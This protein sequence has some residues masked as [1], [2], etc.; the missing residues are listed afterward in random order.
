MTGRGGT[1]ESCPRK[2]VAMRQHAFV[3]DVPP[4]DAPPPVPSGMKRK[5]RARGFRAYAPSAGATT[6]L[7]PRVTLFATSVAVV[8]LLFAMARYMG[9]FDT[10]TDKV[11]E[12]EA[13]PKIGT[14]PADVAAA[15]KI[16]AEKRAFAEGLFGPE[17]WQEKDATEFDESPEWAK[18][19]ATMAKLDPK[20]VVDHLDF[21]LN[22]D[23]DEAIKDPAAFR[24]RM[25]R[26]R[27]LV[28]SNFRAYRLK[29]PVEGREDVFR[30]LIA[31]TDGEHPVFFDVLDAPP[32]FRTMVEKPPGTDIVFSNAD[33]VDVDGVFLRT[34]R[35]ETRGDPRDPKNNP[36][37]WIDVPWVIA[38]TVVKCQVEEEPSNV[39][40]YVGGTA[41][42]LALI[43]L[44]VYLVR[45]DSRPR[46]VREAPPTGFRTMFAQRLDEERRPNSPSDGES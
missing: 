25:V 1:P 42:F 27:G 43:G 32:R 3:S 17:L 33:A 8:V 4:D 31:D 9:A 34:V 37:H 7:P 10:R 36:P 16:A 6:G 35:Y 44:I 21:S 22:N 12:S 20:F 23:Y 15:E 11:F 40:F 2:S 24:G 39:P 28:A 26:M 5:A 41:A 46:P 19:V 13:K 38:R 29:R 14:S 30:G 45:R 18:V